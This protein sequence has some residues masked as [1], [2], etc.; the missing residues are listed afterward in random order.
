MPKVLITGADSFI[1]TN[2][3]KFSKQ[4]MIKAISIIINEQEDID[5]NL[6]D[7]VLHLAAIVHQDNKI[8]KTEYFRVNRDLC[9]DVAK[10]AKQSGIK[11]FIFL[12]TT[13][14]Y[15]RYIPGSASWNEDS[16]C[17]P[18][19]AY[20]QSK[21]EAEK[22][23]KKLETPE[24]T[25]SIIR[26]PIVYGPGVKA[27][28]LSLIKVVEKSPFLPFAGVNNNRHFIYVENLVG[29]I[30]RIIETGISGTFLVMDDKGISTTCL[31]KNLASGFNRKTRLFKLPEFILKSGFKMFPK[32]FGSLFGSFKMDNSKTKEILGYNPP[33]SIEE[34]IR[35]MIS[36]YL[37]QKNIHPL[38]K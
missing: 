27:N 13:K 23:L 20:A 9:L 18:E 11:Q 19:D 1:G 29:Y 37:N 38:K 5:Y 15:G 33:F 7:A 24:F 16:P 31:V 28:M 32:Y 3:Q 2:F 35:R 25:V 17:F 21:Y 22:E 10:R 6:F 8:P 30:D 4:Q 36:Y 14:V 34:G 12:S 26:T